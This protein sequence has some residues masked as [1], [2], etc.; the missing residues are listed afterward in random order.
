MLAIKASTAA[1]T[2]EVPT[3]DASFEFAVQDGK[4]RLRKIEGW[5]SFPFALDVGAFCKP[6][7]DGG[8]QQST[9]YQLLGVV[10][11]RGESLRCAA[12]AHVV[13]CATLRLSC[14]PIWLHTLLKLAAVCGHHCHAAQCRHS[15]EDSVCTRCANH[16]RR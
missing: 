1:Y 10:E 2:V 16:P 4:G 12:A 8:P 9:Q 6:P 13:R 3:S 5:V 15:L 7:A 11:H 14:P